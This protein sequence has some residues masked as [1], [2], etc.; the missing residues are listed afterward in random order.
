MWVPSARQELWAAPTVVAPL[1]P[2]CCSPE[3]HR[4]RCRPSRSP[5][6]QQARLGGAGCWLG[7]CRAEVKGVR[8]GG[9]RV[10]LSVIP[11]Q[12]TDVS[13]VHLQ[14]HAAASAHM[15][16]LDGDYRC[17]AAIRLDTHQSIVTRT[18][19]R[20]TLEISFSHRNA[21]QGLEGVAA[22]IVTRL[23]VFSTPAMRPRLAGAAA[24]LVEADRK[25]FNNNSKSH[26]MQSDAQRCT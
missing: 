22:A 20:L 1:H 14:H 16:H 9:A 4:S 13:P 23:S 3:T 24:L 12:A 17:G 21:L 8:R 26:G 2:G 10:Q 15:Q 7:R 25:V 19:R 18:A 6:W 11:R 5:P